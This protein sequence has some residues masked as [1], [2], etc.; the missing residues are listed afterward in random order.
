[1]KNS[2]LTSNNSLV[3]HIPPSSYRSHQ[4]F[5]SSII[6]FSLVMHLNPGWNPFYFS[7][8]WNIWCIWISLS[9]LSSTIFPFLGNYFA[10][11]Y[12]FDL[13]LLTFH[14]IAYPPLPSKHSLEYI[15]GHQLPNF[16][17]SESVSYHVCF[18][19]KDV[20]LS[21]LFYVSHKREG[22]LFPLIES[23]CSISGK[24][25]GVNENFCLGFLT[26]HHLD[27]DL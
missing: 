26:F 17:I 1:M 19:F 23:Y 5:I 20:V 13:L 21:L 8:S 2:P 18:F 11:K 6:C 14:T 25:E 12:S 7:K 24:N 15:S 10:A 4:S 22:Y 27:T 9:E 3:R 16:W